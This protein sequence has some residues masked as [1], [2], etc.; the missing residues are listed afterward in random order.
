MQI[1][2]VGARADPE[3][4]QGESPLKTNEQFEKVAGMLQWLFRG[5]S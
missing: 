2:A 5:T 3:L 1:A 4:H